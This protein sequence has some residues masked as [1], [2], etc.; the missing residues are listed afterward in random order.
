MEKL[1]SSKIL[2]FSLI[3]LIAIFPLSISNHF[4]SANDLVKSSVIFMAG[5]FIIVYFS[6]LLVYYLVKERKAPFIFYHA[7]FL[8]LS[9]II[10]LFA[11]VISTLYSLRP[12]ISFWGTYERHIGLVT[13][14]YLTLLY[15]MSGVIFSDSKRR[16][17]ALRIIEIISVIISI[18]AI[19]QFLSVDFFNLQPKGIKRPGSFIGYSV[20]LGGFLVLSFPFSVL[21]T[22]GKENKLLRIFFPLI[23]FL[24]IIVSGTRSAY[25]AVL[26]QFVVIIYI[27]SKSFWEFVLKNKFLIAVT[28]SAAAILVFLF[29]FVFNNG[30]LIQRILG[31]A[32]INNPRFALWNDSFN[33]FYKY[34]VTGPGLAMFPA[35]LEEFYSNALRFS[36]ANVT[37]DHAHNNYLQIL[38]TMGLV[39]FLAY[40]L[41][42][43]NSFHTTLKSLKS[44]EASR[45]SK[46]ICTALILMLT[47][48][49]VYGLTNFDDISILFLF[50]IILSFLRSLKLKKVEISFKGFKPFAAAIV[51]LI[52]LL[53]SLNFAFTIN[54]LRADNSYKLAKISYNKGDFKEALH[55]NNEAINLNPDCAAYRYFEA[56]QVYNYCFD[57]SSIDEKAKISL[58]NQVEREIE[59]IKGN[60]YYTNYSNGL[61]SLVYFEE[62]KNKEA[63]ILMHEVLVKD[64]VNLN[65]RLRLCRYLIKVNRLSEAKLSLN[66]HLL[67]RPEEPVTMLLA[68]MYYRKLNDKDNAVFYAGK[69][70]Q[71]DPNNKTALEVMNEYNRK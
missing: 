64:S 17:A 29:L 38:F 45:E 51:I 26:V 55:Y 61:L 18:Y 67:M 11:I 62:G 65:Y 31:G 24:A 41:L 13:F 28:A 12:N 59:K 35:A 27:N 22:A 69:V 16:E 8:D 70:L 36:E 52:I 57:N 10:F 47:G 63:E 53:S 39:G 19:L 2:Y 66:L 49:C 25:I 34:P 46:N 33:I 20:F 44:P 3:L 71:V 54:K 23:I 1:S 9:I 56:S 14:L 50:F 6:L 32:N 68:A 42:I 58:L 60:L 7:G 5:G 37:Y 43:Y 40:I 15:F 48:Y 30:I 21:N 4:F